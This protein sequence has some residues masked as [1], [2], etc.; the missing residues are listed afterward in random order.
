M[1]SFNPYLR[2]GGNCRAAMNFYKDCLGGELYFQTI[3]EGP[4]AGHMP[5]EMNDK[6]M[7]ST[8]TADGF[9]LMASDLAK[10]GGVQRGNACAL[11][12]HFDNEAAIRTA[13]TKLAVGGAQEMALEPTFWGAIY[14]QIIDAYGVEWNLNCA[15]QSAPS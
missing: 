11:M 5:A 8:L 7:H 4:M 13:Y 3:G 12:L 2:F 9:T 10:D 1:T 14:G 15:T 6:I